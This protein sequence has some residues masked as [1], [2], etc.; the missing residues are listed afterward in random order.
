MP[1]FGLHD[2]GLIELET[3]VNGV[4]EADLA[5]IGT[6][7][8][9]PRGEPVM[10]TVGYGATDT[11][12]QTLSYP[13]TRHYAKLALSKGN[14]RVTQTHLKVS[15]KHTAACFGDS[16]GPTYVGADLSVVYG[17]TSFGTDPQCAGWN[18][19]IRTDTQEAH[20]F[21]GAVD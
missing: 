9:L 20:D 4:P 16:G 11:K 13:A 19:Q 12:G 18:Y 5:P 6:A 21:Y 3:P 14:A 15:G 8:G 10:E 7:D 17:I 2:Y 1:F